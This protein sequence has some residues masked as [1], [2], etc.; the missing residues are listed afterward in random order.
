[1]PRAP[2]HGWLAIEEAKR[3]GDPA[4]AERHARAALDI[5][6]ALADP[7][8][9]CMALAQLGRAVVRQGRVAR[10]PSCSTRR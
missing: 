7:D 6:H 2:E 1:V 9:E 10:A 3:A 4:E 8:I 5:A